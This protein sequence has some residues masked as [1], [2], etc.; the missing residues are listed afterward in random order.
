MHFHRVEKRRGEL[1]VEWHSPCIQN[2][3]AF[4]TGRAR[5]RQL[6]YRHTRRH[7]GSTT[8]TE[9]RERESWNGCGFKPTWIKTASTQ[10]LWLNVMLLMMHL[11]RKWLM[12]R[13]SCNRA[14]KISLFQHFICFLS[15]T[16]SN[17]NFICLSVILVTSQLQCYANCFDG[18]AG[19]RVWQWWEWFILILMITLHLE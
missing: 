13:C 1:K 5:T 7:N 8:G 12:E 6:L 10:T 4:Q 2:K 9:N 3:E 14:W 18:E 17:Q 15:L 19:R 16:K 11:R